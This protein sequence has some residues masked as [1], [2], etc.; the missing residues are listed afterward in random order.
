MP[1]LTA[2]E[3]TDVYDELGRMFIELDANPNRG[4]QYVK[5]RLTL[6]RA[7]RDRGGELLLRCSRALS[8]VMG[9]E[10]ALRLEY[11]LAPATPL[12]QRIMGVVG[13]KKD[14]QLLLT[15][16]KAQ[17]SI[18]S[19]TSMDIRLLADLTKEQI[20]LGEI[21]PKDGP[22]LVTDVTTKE[23]ADSIIVPDPPPVPDPPVV[24]MTP[25]PFTS[26]LQPV[27]TLS[28]PS[29]TIKGIEGEAP[30]AQEAPVDFD[31]L[32]GALNGQPGARLN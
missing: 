27:S 30:P 4:L 25:M 20:K 24:E 14:H 16:V 7:M 29:D 8:E 9:E 17:V 2:T 31:D 18:L 26:D 12:E 5:E 32:F 6:C 28:P 11:Q 3:I 13:E 22:G 10:L 23:L 21:D 15:M 19:R 1:K